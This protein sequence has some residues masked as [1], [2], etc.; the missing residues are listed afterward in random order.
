MAGIRTLALSA[1]VATTAPAHVAAQLEPTT[2]EVDADTEQEPA[3]PPD[4]GDGV[5]P[6]ADDD[7]GGGGDGSRGPDEAGDAAD[8]SDE[9]SGLAQ[10]D[11]DGD[12]DASDEFSVPFQGSAEQVE[13]EQES[14]GEVGF[15]PA[16]S[17]DEQD[18]G[19]VRAPVAARNV[20]EQLDW[21]APTYDLRI[22]VAEDVWFRFAGLLQLRLSLNR[23]GMPLDNDGMPLEGQNFT[24]GAQI[25][26]F[27]LET[28]VGLTRYLRFKVRLG[29]NFSNDFNLE[30]AFAD[31]L[32]SPVT[33]R[34][35]RFWLPLYMGG[36][37]APGR[38]T[39]V[40][41]TG[42]VSLFDAGQSQGFG[43]FFD[44]RRVRVRAYLVDGIRTGFR[45]F[46][47]AVDGDGA[48]MARV[49][50][51]LLESSSWADFDSFS[52]LDGTRLG[53]RLGVSGLALFGG[54]TGSTDKA[55]RIFLTADAQLQGDGWH[56]FAA[57]SWTRTSV[58]GAGGGDFDDFG[59]M[60]QAGVF[61]VYWIELWA[62]FDAVFTP[63]SQEP[64][65]DP[66]FS[67]PGLNDFREVLAGVNFFFLPPTYRARV[68]ADVQYALDPISTSSV[69]PASGRTVLAALGQQW[70][71][72]LQLVLEF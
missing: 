51:R 4:G 11:E 5:P 25:P 26:R 28:W 6:A 14:I 31:F 57:G 1:L 43:A 20:G 40:D 18:A 52:A 39:A 22:D 30:Q 63:V 72:R 54:R 41:Y 65:P 23:R 17:V 70:A 32:I 34:V 33:L 46:G 49:E 7:E 45:E 71:V 15:S 29:S 19:L 68:Q 27:R 35:G 13:A 42:T 21:T 53:L 2:D 16:A 48:V 69:P 56:V 62:A 60:L 9:P 64:R 50:T 44:I 3:D 36:A 8:V 55:D 61:V 37:P 59:L 12:D 66:P 58:R 10:D 67:Q 24:T 47:Q 38:L